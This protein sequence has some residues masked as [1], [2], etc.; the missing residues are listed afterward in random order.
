MASVNSVSL[1]DEFDGYKSDIFALRKEGKISI[2]A[3]VVISGLCH[4]L[5]VVIAIFLEKVAK[6]TSKNF[7]IPPS[8]TDKDETKKSSK[9]IRDASAA[10]KLMTGE[11]FQTTT[12]EEISTVEV[13]DNCGTDFSDIEPSAREQRVLRDIRFTVEEVK[14]DAEI[15]D[16]PMCSA[17]T[18]GRF[19]E[20]MPG[21]LQYD[22]GIKASVI[23]LLV[24]QMVSL[25]R[26]VGLA[27][28]MSGI[29]LSEATC[30]DYIQR[31]HDA[32]EARE[33]AAK[34]HL[35]T[36]PSLHVDETCLKVNKKTHWMPINS[37]GKESHEIPRR[38]EGKRGRIAKPFA[39]NLLERLLKCEDSV[40][41]FTSDPD[42]SFTNNTAAQ[43]TGCQRSKSKSRGASG[44]NATSTPSAGYRVIS[45]QWENSDTI[46][47]TPFRSRLTEMPLT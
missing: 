5:G 44:Q 27:Q 19:P 13:C 40:L 10:Q 4:L 23:S 22:N 28:V 8:Q 31:L 14:V 32:L 34:E 3:D 17:R 33:A 15:K 46:H 7:S 39:H 38:R 9:K 12:V 21:P 18:K 37:G 36:C 20:N 24:T 41:R 2:E 29:N 45:I 1:R 42:V 11:N 26:A 6:K 16:C 25:N 43:K 35:L 47:S 30:L